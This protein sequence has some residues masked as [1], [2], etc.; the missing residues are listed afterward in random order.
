MLDCRTPGPARGARS[1]VGAGGRCE[2]GFTGNALSGLLTNFVVALQNAGGRCPQQCQP[3]C[4]ADN[5][6]DLDRRENPLANYQ[7]LGDGAGASAVAI[8][9]GSTRSLCAPRWLDNGRVSGVGR[10]TGLSY[11]CGAE[12]LVPCMNACISS[13][14]SRPSLLLSIA[15]KIRS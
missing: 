15:L 9:S 1:G 8:D 14:V 5:L 10:S 4:L 3:H 2:E 7:S 12:L 6:L 11:C 13:K